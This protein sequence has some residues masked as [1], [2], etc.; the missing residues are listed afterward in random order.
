ML[1][2]FRASP[3]LFIFVGFYGLFVLV[4]LISAVLTRD[5]EVPARNRLL[6]PRQPSRMPRAR[7]G[8][9]RPFSHRASRRQDGRKW[10][11]C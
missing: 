4:G 8:I 10:R 6:M 1:E 11:R 3:R 7:L 5:R 9:G 2:I